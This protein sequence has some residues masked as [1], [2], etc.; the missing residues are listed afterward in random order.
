MGVCFS[1]RQSKTAKFKGSCSLESHPFLR[2]LWCILCCT[3]KQKYICQHVSASVCRIHACCEDLTF[4]QVNGGHSVCLSGRD[5]PASEIP[6]IMDTISNMKMTNPIKGLVSK[7]RKRYM[8][9]GFNL[10]LACILYIQMFYYQ[11]LHL[12]IIFNALSLITTE[13]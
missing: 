10:D 6:A 5:S 13:N 1:C 2:F 8:A 9:D 11:N 3:D 7:R 4:R 12:S